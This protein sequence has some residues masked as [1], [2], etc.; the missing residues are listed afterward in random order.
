MWYTWHMARRKSSA[1]YHSLAEER[2]FRWLGPEV[3]NTQTRTG[4]RCARDHRWEARYGD[5][6]QGK[7]CPVCAGTIR[8]TPADYHALAGSLG[9]RWLGPVV[10]NVKT[11]TAWR[12]E[13]G[14]TWQTTYDSIRSGKGCPVCGV[15]TV[16]EKRRTQ[17]ASYH[18]LAKERGFRWLG[19]QVA[20]VRDNTGWSCDKGHEWQAT[21]DNIRRGRG[22][23][24]CSSRVPLTPA[25]Y[26]SLAAER[27]F[28]WLG[29]EVG[30]NRSNTGWRCRLGHEWQAPY[31]NMKQGSGCPIYWGKVPLTV[32]DYEALASTTTVV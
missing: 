14:H 21:F 5:I 13:Q 4:W 2:G 9:L 1:D 10:P 23:P 11:K 32:A 31:S 27:G 12:C 24:V 22:C 20:S 6:Q 29:P 7:G 17:P 30:N 28:V 26:R 15:A 25:D 18:S 16:A 8:K 3:P 19:P